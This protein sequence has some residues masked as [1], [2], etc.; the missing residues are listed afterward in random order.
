[1]EGNK[2]QTIEE[3][4]EFFANPENEGKHCIATMPDGSEAAL[5]S[6]ENAENH[7]AELTA[8]EDAGASAEETA[9]EE[10]KAEEGVN[11]GSGEAVQDEAAAAEEKPAEE[12]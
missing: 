10:E 7:F 9:T 11:A 1:M 12:A 4:R 3:A 2:I 5:V 6:V 8:K